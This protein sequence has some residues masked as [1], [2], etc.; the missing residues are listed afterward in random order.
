[1]PKV[2]APEGPGAETAEM[3]TTRGGRRLLYLGEEVSEPPALLSRVSDSC[4]LLAL[5]P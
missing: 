5:Y 3:S 4:L 1:M 2:K